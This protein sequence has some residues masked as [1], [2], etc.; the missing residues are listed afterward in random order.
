MCVGEIDRAVEIRCKLTGEFDVSVLRR[1]LPSRSKIS[2]PFISLKPPPVPA[3]IFI[4][5][6]PPKPS[7]PDDDVDPRASQRAIHHPTDGTCT[8]RVPRS[9][10]R[11]GT[12]SC[13]AMSLMD[14]VVPVVHLVGDVASGFG[15]HNTRFHEMIERWR[16]RNRGPCII[17]IRLDFSTEIAPVGV[18]GASIGSTNSPI[19]GTTKKWILPRTAVGRTFRLTPD[20]SCR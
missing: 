5:P 17:A 4:L 3:V 10:P 14:S 6:L 7:R 13:P 11:D 12:Y 8:G 15:W 16:E 9:L 20:H 2:T 18:A 19:I 1:S